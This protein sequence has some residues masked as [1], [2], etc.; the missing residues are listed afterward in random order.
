V[1]QHLT[2]QNDFQIGRFGTGGPDDDLVQSLVGPSAGQGGDEEGESV[3]MQVAILEGLHQ[4]ADLPGLDLLQEAQA[5]GIDAQVAGLA[6][7]GP[8]SL[9]HGAVATHRDGGGGGFLRDGNARGLQGPGQRIGH[10]ARPDAAPQEDGH[11]L[12]QRAHLVLAA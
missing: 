1:L 6:S 10:A 3:F 9:Q 7:V 2:L 5:S 4:V 12:V 11:R 8:E